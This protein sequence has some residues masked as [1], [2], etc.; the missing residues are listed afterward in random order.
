MRTW[1]FSG[2]IYQNQKEEAEDDVQCVTF[3]LMFFGRD[4]SLHNP[5]TS[6]GSRT[7]TATPTVKIHLLS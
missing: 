2:H 4:H 1:P 6:Q 5:F 7:T 3:F